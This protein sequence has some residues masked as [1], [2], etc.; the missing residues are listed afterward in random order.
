MIRYSVILAFFT[1]TLQLNAQPEPISQ[2]TDMVFSNLSAF[3]LN[4]GFTTTVA[5]GYLV[6][7]ST[8]Y[9]NATVQDGTTY[10]KGQGI[11][12][13]KVAYVGTANL[14]IAREILENTKYHFTV[15]AYN[16]SGSNINYNITNPLRDSVTT[17]AANPG[18]YYDAIDPTSPNFVSDLHNLV[19]PH[20]LISYSPGYISTILPVMYE[21]DTTGGAAVVNCEYSNETTV[22]QPPFSFTTQAYNR[23]HVLCKSWML[24]SPTFGSSITNQP[25][26]ADQFNLLLTRSTPNQSRSNNPLGIVVN[27]TTQFGEARIG[28]NAS[29]S[30]VFEPK[31]NRKGDA[32]RAMMYQMVC[33]TGIG[34][35]TWG[36]DNLLSLAPNQDQSILKLW[37]QQDPPDEFER[38]KNEY[39]Y[40]IQRN[41]NPFI[42]HPE[43]VACINFDSLTKTALC[44]GNAIEEDSFPDYNLATLYPNP[45]N[46]VINIR[47][48]QTE[49]GEYI[50][51]IKNELGQSIYT[52]ENFD[53]SAGTILSLNT[54]I[55]QEGIYFVQIQ[56]QKFNQVS[57][58][59]IVR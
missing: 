20:T 25:E 19:N 52:L 32:A 2:P 50:I 40:S 38:T 37:H 35:G 49:V 55:F 34:G 3:S 9:I 4:V 18:S 5:D 42:D 47:F 15:Y 17:P 30:V 36:L 21:R 10:T 28:T 59:C 1:A 27:T 44:V 31:N 8:R 7:K 14:F 6:L 48:L 51:S 29:G 41:R 54:S 26:G 58:I 46:D 16:G 53:A 13:A 56:S 57:T 33:Y 22:Y 24:T 43:W 23:E 45:A 12:N 11:G 39:I